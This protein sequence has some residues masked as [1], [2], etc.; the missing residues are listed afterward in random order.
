MDE[1][2]LPDDGRY[3]RAMESGAQILTSDRTIGRADLNAPYTWLNTEG[4]TVTAGR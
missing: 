1:N 3:R 2:L 4:I